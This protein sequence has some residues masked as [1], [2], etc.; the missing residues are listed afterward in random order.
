MILGYEIQP[1]IS[2]SKRN[3]STKST[4]KERTFDSNHITY[5]TVEKD[6]TLHSK[7]QLTN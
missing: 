3:I 5:M 1:S 4:N 2:L 7:L 6:C